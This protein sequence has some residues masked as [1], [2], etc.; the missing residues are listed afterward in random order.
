[1]VERATWN[2]GQALS[3]SLAYRLKGK[4]YLQSKT[5]SSVHSN[6]DPHFARFP[7]LDEGG[8]RHGRKRRRE[9]ALKLA[10]LAAA[11][12]FACATGHA[13]QAAPDNSKR[14]D[15]D[16]VGKAS[17][18]DI[19]KESENPIGNL[20]VLPLENYTNFG[21]GPH[22]GTLN[23][24][25]FEPV[26]PIHLTPDWNLIT[27]VVI[28][29]VWTPD[30]SPA[31]SVPQAIAPADFFAFLSPR[32]ATNGWLWGVGPIIQI[33]TATSPTVGSSVWGL[34]PTAVVVKTTEHVVAGV[35]ANQVWSLGGVDS[36]PGGRRYATF[37]VEP[38]FNYNFG[39]GWFV[40]SD[41]I[42][43]ANWETRGTKWTV[44]LG[45]GFGRIIKLAASCRSNCRSA[46][47]TMS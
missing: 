15:H 47:S 9:E 29:A 18:D 26:V 4:W 42:I 30:L 8:K 40:F 7:R 10:A 3:Y 37:L 23:L 27:R 12:L 41:P 35:L 2:R 45:A 44:P 43:T 14:V 36:G 16:T 39:G 17:E 6:G 46:A 25:E 19:A 24:L 21:V 20:T 33:P 38:F 1:M 11:C 31:K 5:V 28:P 13:Q 32:N 22:H 34:G